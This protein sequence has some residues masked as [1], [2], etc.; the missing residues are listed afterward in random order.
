VAKRKHG[1]Q[2]ANH[3]RASGPAYAGLRPRATAGRESANGWLTYADV[4]CA[5]CGAHVRLRYRDGALGGL[6]IGIDQ[7]GSS[8]LCQS[9]KARLRMVL[10]AKT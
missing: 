9:C 7:T 4:E 8:V 3:Q 2:A 1:R 6:H 5:E 10:G